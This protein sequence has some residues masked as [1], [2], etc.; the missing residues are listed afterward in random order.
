MTD[1][2]TSESTPKPRRRSVYSTS[3]HEKYI[4]NEY[5]NIRTDL[6]HVSHDKLE[7]ILIKSYQKHLLRYAWF[8]PLSILLALGLSIATSDFKTT[9]FGINAA[10]WRAFFMLTLTLSSIWLVYT[11]IQLVKNWND[12]S[13]ESLIN[14]IKNVDS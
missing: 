9:A 1:E 5:S 3:G 4:D 14:R 6:I 11:I 12:S 13:I 8:N 7:N 2:Q 10:T